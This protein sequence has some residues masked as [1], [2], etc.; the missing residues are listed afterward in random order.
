MVGGRPTQALQHALAPADNSVCPV[1]LGCGG[2]AQLG[3]RLG[4]ATTP[5]AMPLRIG[6]DACSPNAPTQRR[7]ARLLGWDRKVAGVTQD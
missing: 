2:G 7:A 3:W 1:G 5:T 6:F 4:G